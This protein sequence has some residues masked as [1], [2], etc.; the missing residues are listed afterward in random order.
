MIELVL[1]FRQMSA[2]IYFLRAYSLEEDKTIK[3][4][5]CKEILL[6]DLT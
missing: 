4:N 3:A 2:N 6:F 5:I 1:G